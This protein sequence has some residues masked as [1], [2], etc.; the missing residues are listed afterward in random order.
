MQDTADTAELH[1]LRDPI[2]AIQWQVAQRALTLG[3][4]V[5]LEWGFW[6]RQERIYYRTEA[7]ALGAQVELHYLDVSLDE[8]WARLSQRN[9]NLPPGTFH[10]TREQLEMFDSWFERPSAEELESYRVRK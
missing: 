4:N 7:E 8:L 6:S 2:E 1:R 5:I 3:L 9:A 10:V